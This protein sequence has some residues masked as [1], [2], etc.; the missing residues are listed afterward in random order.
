METQV[1]QKLAEHGV[2][3]ILVFI[4][5]AWILSLHKELGRERAA[6]LQDVKDGFDMATKMQLASA[7]H[8][9][10]LNE[11]LIDLKERKQEI[12]RERAQERADRE[13]DP[14]RVR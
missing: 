3:G 5:G 8:A 7:K 10:T 2:L 6:R 4:M 14:R 1:W 11:T 12:E 13:R 9:E